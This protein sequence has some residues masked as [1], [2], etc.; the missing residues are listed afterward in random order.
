[1]KA[2]LLA[3]DFSHPDCT[4]GN[5]VMNFEV[6]LGGV[7]GGAG[8]EI[9]GPLKEN[10]WR[11]MRDAILH[12]PDMDNVTINWALSFVDAYAPKGALGD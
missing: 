5:M 12:A 8:W 6:P 2:N 7:V 10:P 1:M 11:T 9:Y 4:E 3:V